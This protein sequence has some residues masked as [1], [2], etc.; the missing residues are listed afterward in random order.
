[1]LLHLSLHDLRVSEQ[2]FQDV[3]GEKHLKS[4]V[5]DLLRNLTWPGRYEIDVSF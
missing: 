4:E 2:N 5:M 1:M 3:K